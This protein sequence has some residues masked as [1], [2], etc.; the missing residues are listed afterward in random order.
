MQPSS[1]NDEKLG[2]YGENEA[3]AKFFAEFNLCW[4][5][6]PGKFLGAVK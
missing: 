3:K 5:H 4:L 1:A 2:V 6:N